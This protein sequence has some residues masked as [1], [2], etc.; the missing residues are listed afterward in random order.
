VAELAATP[1]VTPRMAQ[2]I[3][4]HF[5]PGDGAGRGEDVAGP[6]Q[7]VSTNGSGTERSR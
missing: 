6:G 7:I 5:H 4:D 3:Y 2:R 1:K